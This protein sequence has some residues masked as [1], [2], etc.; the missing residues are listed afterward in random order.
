MALFKKVTIVGVGLLGGSIG[1]GIKKNDLAKNVTGFFRHKNEIA[2]ALTS[3]IVDVGTDDFNKAVKDSDLIILCSPVGDIIKRLKTMKHKA[4]I[5]DTGS[6]KAEIAKAGRK[7]NFIGSHPLAGSE[8]SGAQFARADL[9]HSSLCI[10]TPDS[11]RSSKALPLVKKFWE[12]LGARTILLSPKEHDR[13]VAFSSHLPHAL[14]FALMGAVPQE[15][16]PFAAGGLK[17]TTRI[18]LSSPEIWADIFLS[19]RRQVAGS[20][21]TFEKSLKELKKS[22]L[23]NNRKKL[24][25]LLKHAQHKRRS[26]PPKI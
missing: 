25:S 1:L 19:N 3:G 13:I 26:I 20:I 11:S 18:S 24:L 10:L 12:G 2:H 22:I 15:I 4:L 17:D 21:S 5:T 9:F 7:L 8:Q 6:T 16:I 14:A 23:N